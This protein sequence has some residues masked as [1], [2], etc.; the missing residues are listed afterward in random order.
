MLQDPLLNF[1]HAMPTPKRAAMR[2]EVIE[3]VLVSAEWM[4]EAVVNPSATYI[5]IL[6]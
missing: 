5:P 1:M 4:G 2:K 6:D 3:A